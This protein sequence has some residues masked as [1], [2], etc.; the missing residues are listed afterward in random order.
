MN[1]ELEGRAKQWE[2]GVGM[3]KE[4]ETIHFVI[5]KRKS[6]GII[7]LVFFSVLVLSG[8]ML[9]LFSLSRFQQAKP[10]QF[11][12]NLHSRHEIFTY[13]KNVQEIENQFYDI[14]HQQKQLSA[15][16][17]F[18]G[19]QLVSL[20][21]KAIPALEQLMIDLAKTETNPTIMENYHLFSEEIKSMRD[22][23]VENKFG[24]EKN[25]PISRER[26]GKYIDRYALVSR[27]RRENLKTLFDRYNISYID[28][29]DKIKYKVK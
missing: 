8:S 14:V 29:G 10:I 20:Y 2:W 24:I 23:M 5:N 19:H 9:Y 25:D 6:I 22:A 27:L 4:R 3:N 11:I 16:E 18:N 13:L 17:D 21:E 7:M 15:S 12:L 1:V 28:M 26:A